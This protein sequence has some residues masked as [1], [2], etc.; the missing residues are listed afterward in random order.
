L[1]ER[2]LAA[3]PLAVRTYDFEVIAFPILQMAETGEG[4]PMLDVDELLGYWM[5]RVRWWEEHGV[6]VGQELT[7][8]QG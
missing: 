8:M 1:E 7:R 2:E 3:L 5:M 4:Y 6:E